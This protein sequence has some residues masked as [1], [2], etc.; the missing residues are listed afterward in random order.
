MSIRTATMSNSYLPTTRRHSGFFRKL[1]FTFLFV[2][3][4]AVFMTV[5]NIYQTNLSPQL[6][7]IF[8][9]LS[10]GLA[11]GSGA[12][13][14]FYEWSGFTRF[15]V[16]LFVL[17]IGMLVLGLLTS[18]EMGIGPLD[19]WIRKE[20]DT[21]Q[22]IQLGGALLVAMI[23][24]DAWWK[25]RLKVEELP[26]AQAAS[27]RREKTPAAVSIQSVQPRSP[28]SHSQPKRNWRQKLSRAN[29]PRRTGTISAVDKLIIPHSAPQAT[30]RRRRLSNRKPKLQIS[31]FEEHR[32]PYCLDV[33]K[34][35]DPRGI[36]ECEVCHSLHHADCWNITGM[37]QVPHLNQ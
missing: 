26:E 1:V 21:D 24:L 23:S 12:R 20:I 35:N 15:L 18:W 28:Q 2:I 19:P 34:R 32:C 4:I 11:A 29:K 14:V 16:I 13:L 31:V 3:G 10:L 33:V 25:P 22:L 6:M 9:I 7:T 37:C 36:K 17:P 30:S 8:A 27:N 5:L